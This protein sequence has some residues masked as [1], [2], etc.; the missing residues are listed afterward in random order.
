MRA[1]KNKMGVKFVRGEKF[2][3]AVIVALILAIP[4][5]NVVS[6]G[7]LSETNT[8]IERLKN[9]IEDQE[10]V[11][12]SLSMQIDELAS[13]ENI[14]NIAEEHGLSYNNSNI[15]TINQE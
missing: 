1:T 3:Y 12:Q 8:E 15:K 2:L 9:K 4:T 11:N 14:Q 6:S 7:L 13:L 5:L 10:L